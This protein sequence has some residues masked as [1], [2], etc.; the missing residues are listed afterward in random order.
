MPARQPF[1]VRRE[2]KDKDT[3][4]EDINND[5]EDKEE[6]DNEKSHHASKAAIEGEQEA[7]FS[8]LCML[9][10]QLQQAHF[11]YFASMRCWTRY[12]KTMDN[13]CRP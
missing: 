10:Q 13:V 9:P 11:W 12:K 2:L 7:P 8:S 4:K 6:E 5:K 1:R 3:D